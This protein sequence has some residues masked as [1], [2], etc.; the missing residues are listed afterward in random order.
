[1]NKAAEKF[2]V[3]IQKDVRIYIHND[4]MNA[5]NFLKGKIDEQRKEGDGDGLGL[6]TM[7][8]LTIIAFAFEAQM[9]FLGFK[10]ISNWE[11]RK[12][13]LVKFER[14]A[15]KLN[16]K[17]DYE[18]RPHSTVKKLKEFRD[19]LA[20][21]KPKEI[22]GESEEII[23][24]EEL[25]RRDLLKAEWQNSLTEEFLDRAYDDTEDIWREFLKESGL[26]VIDTITS[27]Q[28]TVQVIKALDPSG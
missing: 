12:P 18:S 9:N 27:G 8:R 3:K 5:A 21:G 19:T 28:Q 22:K 24:R 25:E 16:V 11:E 10:L 20:H 13:Y 17:V 4:L 14:V 23:T 15:K 1:M 2:V 7:A 6:E 26:S